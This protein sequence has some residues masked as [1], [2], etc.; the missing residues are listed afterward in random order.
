MKIQNFMHDNIEVIKIRFDDLWFLA[1]KNRK[2]RLNFCQPTD[3]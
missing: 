2:S 3:K 1:P